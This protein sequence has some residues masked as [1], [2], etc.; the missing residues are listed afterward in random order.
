MAEARISEN[1]FLARLKKKKKI[2]ASAAK[3]LPK[4]FLS[5]EEIVALFELDKSDKLIEFKLSKVSFGV[6]KNGSEFFRFGYIV[7]TEE[8]KGTNLSEMFTLDAKN[9]DNYAK[10]ATR[11]YQKFQRFGYDTTEW[12]DALELLMPAI[13]ELNEAK[14]EGQMTLGS[15]TP[16]L[17]KGQTKKRTFVNYNIVKVYGPGAEDDD[18]EEDDDEGVAVEGDEPDDDGEGEEESEVSETPDESWVGLTAVYEGGEVELKKWN[19]RK[20]QFT[21]YSEAEDAEYIVKPDDLEWEEE[22][23]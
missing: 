9:D 19:A 7:T 13:N 1:Q 21:V 14:P 17:K 15:Y 8:Y 2:L 11:M 4:G 12:E 6:D 3:E 10:A 23:E 16:D 22:E 18:E 20:K 5:D